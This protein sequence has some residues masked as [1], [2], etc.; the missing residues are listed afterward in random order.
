M[1]NPYNADLI[2]IRRQE[3]IEQADRAR[4][5]KAARKAH[6]ER[7]ALAG[8]PSEVNGRASTPNPGLLLGA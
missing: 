8:R 5:A 7:R 4:V 1:Y 2:R 3:L 6:R